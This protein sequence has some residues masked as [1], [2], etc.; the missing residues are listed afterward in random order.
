MLSVYLKPTNYCAINCDHCYLPLPTRQNK[1]RM[2]L[3]TLQNT[4]KFLAQMMEKFKHQHC[5]IIWHGGEPLNMP[6]DWYWQAGEILDKIIPNHSESMQTSL[7][8]FRQ[9]IVELVHQ[10]FASELGSSMDF[11]LR[12]LNNE[13]HLY[14][15]RWL[16]KVKLARSEKIE[17]IPGVVPG[18][19][20]INHAEKI[21]SWFIKHQFMQFNFERFNSFGQILPDRPSNKQHAHFLTSLFDNLMSRFKNN[22]PTPLVGIITSAIRGVL[23]QNPGD[24]WGGGCQSDFI[25]I[26]PDGSLNNCPDK[27]SFEKPMSNSNQSTNKFISA[28]L[29]R[30]WIQ[31]QTLTHKTPDCADCNYYNWCKSGC[32]IT[33]HEEECAGYYSFLN[34]I[35]H[36]SKQPDGLNYLEG[37]LNLRKL[38]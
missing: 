13:A 21:V 6:T 17:I 3:S 34:H 8:A 14:Q 36:F 30:Q 38:Q 7:L 22:K 10:R 35:K 20:D 26:E 28:P 16:D 9:D 33:P 19:Q 29:R 1:D 27:S 32:P 12:K 23:Y 5:H 31:I 11:S 15:Q 24:R 37:Y 4:A 18:K 25:V 2:S